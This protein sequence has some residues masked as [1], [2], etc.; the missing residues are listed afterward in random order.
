LSLDIAGWDSCG[1]TLLMLAV[2]WHKNKLVDYLIVKGA[3][4]NVAELEGKTAMYLAK[5]NRNKHAEEAIKK[6][7]KYNKA[8]YFDKDRGIAVLTSE[9][10]VNRSRLKIPKKDK[11]ELE[12]YGG[13]YEIDCNNDSVCQKYGENNENYDQCKSSKD[14]EL[15]FNYACKYLEELRKIADSLKVTDQDLLHFDNSDS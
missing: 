13:F 11:E 15:I 6:A 1:K 7:A 8:L 14:Y 2:K 5:A 12:K 4:V 10:L 3:D 9:F